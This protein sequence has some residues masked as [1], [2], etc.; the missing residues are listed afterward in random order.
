MNLK[1][2]KIIAV[3]VMLQEEIEMTFTKSQRFKN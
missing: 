1:L 2:Y 3:P